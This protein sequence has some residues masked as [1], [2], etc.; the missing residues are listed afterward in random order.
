VKRN[1]LLGGL[2]LLCL[3]FFIWPQGSPLADSLPLLA[4]VPLFIWLGWPWRR[5]S[6]NPLPR[7]AT[8]LLPAL[9]CLGGFATG[10]MF[11]SVLGWVWFLRIWLGRFD[12]RGPARLSRLLLLPALSFPW[13]AHD[14]AQVGWW[15]R[16]S[17]A[18]SATR[19]FGLLGF[20]V[21]RAGTNVWLQ[22][23]PV[24]VDPAC[25]GLGTLQAMLL[26]GAFLALSQIGHHRRFW[27]QI[28]ALVPF[29][30]VANTARVILTCVALLT[31]GPAFATGAFH[32]W[33][34][35]VLLTL[36]FAL[37]WP[38]LIWQR[39]NLEPARRRV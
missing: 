8:L 17:G 20:E 25:A 36:M 15:F 39:H 4:G 32:S 19:L 1:D 27:W 34:G 18:W 10:L 22:G 33:S 2:A 31:A 9:V 6:D 28:A 38:L 21:S 24:S 7:P 3:G 5:R 26:A 35:W 30:W 12:L 13:I 16:L 29:A 11:P 23:F 37:C 14:L